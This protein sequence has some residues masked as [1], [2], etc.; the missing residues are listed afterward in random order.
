MTKRNRATNAEYETRLD[1]LTG[2][3]KRG[4]SPTQ[5]IR[6]AGQQWGVSIRQAN[7][8]LKAIKERE[9]EN[10]KQPFEFRLSF[11]GMHFDFLYEQAV[12]EKDWELA[13]KVTENRMT[14]YNMQH[15][16]GLDDAIQSEKPGFAKHKGLEELIRMLEEEGRQKQAGS[17]Q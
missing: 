1:A 10:L 7:R 5:L 12:Q 14:L 16:G 2:L 8:Y 3:M 15:K 11:L 4:H 13:R 6:A 9:K 17:D